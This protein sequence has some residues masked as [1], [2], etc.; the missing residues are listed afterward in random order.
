MGQLLAKRPMAWLRL[1]VQQ[2]LDLHDPEWRLGDNAVNSLAK[3]FTANVSF[4]RGYRPYVE[5][6]FCGQ[7][8]RTKSVSA[9]LGSATFAADPIFFPVHAPENGAATSSREP[10]D[11]RLDMSEDQTMA[12]LRFTVRDRRVLQS[13]MRGHPL[14][15]TAILSVDLKMREHG[16]FEEHRIELMRGDECYGELIVQTSVLE[17]C[18]LH[19]VIASNRN[20]CDD[21]PL[22]K[23]VSALI[24]VLRGPDGVDLLMRTR[25]REVQALDHF[26]KVARNHFDELVSQLSSLTTNDDENTGD[27]RLL[28]LLSR[29]LSQGIMCY[30]DQLQTQA[31]RSPG[32]TRSASNSLLS[33]MSSQSLCKL[34]DDSHVLDLGLEWIHSVVSYMQEELGLQ[35][36]ALTL[37]EEALKRFLA[38]AQ[39]KVEHLDAAFE[40]GTV[41]PQWRS[42]VETEAG[43]WWYAARCVNMFSSKAVL[44]EGQYGCV[45]RARERNNKRR[46]LAIKNV[47]VRRIGSIED[48]LAQRELEISERICKAPHPNVV[49][50]FYSDHSAKEG[51]YVQV[52][53]LCLPDDLQTELVGIAKSGGASSHLPNM[54]YWIAQI[55]LG[56]E[57]L[58]FQVQML[59]RDVKPG[60]VLLSEKGV[61]KLA[62]FGVGRL[63]TRSD[64]EWTFGVPPGTACY[65]APEVLQEKEH[66]KPADLYSFGVLVWTILTCGIGDTGLPPQAADPSESWVVFADCVRHPGKHSARPLP[67]YDAMDIVL[68]LTHTQAEMRPTHASIRRHAFLSPVQLP[69]AECDTETVEAWLAQ[70]P[71]WRSTAVTTG[72]LIPG[73][74]RSYVWDAEPDD[75]VICESTQEPRP[76]KDFMFGYQDEQGIAAHQ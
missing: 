66:S 46:L 72:Q 34:D 31:I 21:N 74:E 4:E 44:G 32:L 9:P 48:M 43:G 14:F 41:D 12:N 16:S 57:H 53:E 54:T 73:N 36:V 50:C 19:A 23:V 75:V 8:R 33:V 35:D 58:H 63:G 24:P 67:G 28:D 17:M 22:A 69:Q 37:S 64:G 71:E 30:L 45:W 70:A 68:Q 55:F 6:T 10:K 49:Q 7:R 62:D 60:N 39:L 20:V 1:D 56:L 13:L 59:H 65:C 61:A 42:I 29:R 40:D 2:C 15:G 38:S 5:I 76:N 11:A 52:M 25:P 18:G 26:D 51:L 47:K 27:G 3:S